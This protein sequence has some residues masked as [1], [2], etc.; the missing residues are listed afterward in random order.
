MSKKINQVAQKSNLR[1]RDAQLFATYKK[2]WEEKLEAR[3]VNQEHEL[4]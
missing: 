4:Y 2:R 1:M 3:D